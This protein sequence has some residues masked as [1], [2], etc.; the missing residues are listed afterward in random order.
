MANIVEIILKGNDQSSRAISSTVKNL[1]GMDS[2]LSAVRRSLASL[3]SVGALVALAKSAIDLGGALTDMSAKF[4]VS[5]SD[6][7]ALSYPAKMVGVDIEAVGNAFKFMQKNIAAAANPTSDQAIALK[8]LGVSLDELK[9]KTPMDQFLRLADAFSRLERD[10]NRTAIAL[11]LFGRAG[12]DVLPVIE[13]GGSELKRM[14][15]AAQDL[16]IALTEEE[17][18][19]LDDYGD[20]IDRLSLRTKSFAGRA[21]NELGEFYR[22]LTR[23]NEISVNLVSTLNAEYDKLLVK[24]GLINPSIKQGK[25]ADILVPNSEK[26][27]AGSTEEEK[28][29]IKAAEE[30]RKKAAA[31][32]G[33]L[34]EDILKHDAAQ[35]AAEG[36]IVHD[37]LAAEMGMDQEY[38]DTRTKMRL[39]DLEEWKK[40]KE[41][42]AKLLEKFELD[43]IG[44]LKDLQDAQRAEAEA[45]E[46]PKSYLFEDAMAAAEAYGNVSL[47]IQT[48]NSDLGAQYAMITEGQAYISLYK[49]AWL[50]ANLAIADSTM[51]LYSGMQGWISSSLQ[52]LVEGTM[53]VQDVLKNL[54][55]MML[56]IIT[57]YL[58][59][60]I[61]SRV[62]MLAMGKSFQAAEVAA[63]LVTGGAVAAAWAPAAALVEIATLG[64]ASVAAAAGLASTVALA[65]ALAIPALAEGGIVHRPTLALIGE[66]GPEAVVPLGKGGGGGD[67][68]LDGSLVGRW[69]ERR[70]DQ[71]GGMKL[72][73][74]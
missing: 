35:A 28:A 25:I 13:K 32:A 58:A 66:N 2:A 67:V 63:A 65:Q 39:E 20:A 37:A 53:A 14:M 72:R 40:G 46:P 74:T 12:A 38:F 61:V 23:Q 6:L 49:Q 56:S 36:K 60:W 15:K 71:Y 50:D 57:D 70:A 18:K 52:G 24:M 21:V 3:V 5:A 44:M 34:K 54:G 43:K 27:K 8:L 19:N 11:D 16:G 30:A 29:R 1:Q 31:A 4:G 55:K 51:S 47:A 10:E 9:N 45:D 64:G 7:S 41:D 48:M 59:K 68:Y 22:W 69:L 42:E 73:F 26:A 33:K 62:T 17:I